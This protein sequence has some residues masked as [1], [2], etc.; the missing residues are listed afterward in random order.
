MLKQVRFRNRDVRWA[1]VDSTVEGPVEVTNRVARRKH[2]EVTPTC[3]Q[4]V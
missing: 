1:E 2:A 3:E 4:E